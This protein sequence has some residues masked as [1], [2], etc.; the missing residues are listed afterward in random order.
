MKFYSKKAV[1]RFAIQALTYSPPNGMLDAAEKVGLGRE[2]G[3][4]ST[5]AS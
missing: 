4:L 5:F 2:R 3:V 1:A